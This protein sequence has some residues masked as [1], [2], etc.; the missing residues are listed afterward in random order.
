MVRSVH[1]WW[2][3]K[4]AGDIPDRADLD[5]ADLKRLLPNLFIADVEH[6]PFRIR[7]RLMGT[8]AIEATGM[9]LTGRYLDELLPADL[10]EPWMDYY[11]RAYRT[12]RPLFG[13]CEAPTTSGR[14]F[15]YEFGLFPLR[16]GGAT[17]EQ[18]LAIEDYFDLTSTLIE[19]VEWRARKAAGAPRSA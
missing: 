8:R 16:K 6:A 3:D 17:V 5:P 14:R 4:S 11:H 10:D 19:L 1:R 9:D 7:Y 18:F 2:L 13:A 15:I 12:R